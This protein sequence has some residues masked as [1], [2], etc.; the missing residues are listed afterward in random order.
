M[1]GG[2]PK[3][4]LNSDLVTKSDF[5]PHKVLVIQSTREV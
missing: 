2:S 5:D 4:I 1:F 3:V